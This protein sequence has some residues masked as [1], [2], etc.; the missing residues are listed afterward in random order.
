MKAMILSEVQPVESRPLRMMDLPEPAPGPR[1]ILVKVAVCGV[2]HTELDEI[3]GRIQ[4]KL[5]VILGHEIVGKVS[6]LGPGART[7]RLGDRVGIGWVPS[8]C[9]GCGFCRSGER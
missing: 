6:A 9:G 5:P 8:S 1:E 7:F 4:P 2:C 3:E